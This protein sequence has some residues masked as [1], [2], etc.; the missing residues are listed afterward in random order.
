MVMLKNLIR[1]SKMNFISMNSRRK[2]TD[3]GLN[4]IEFFELLA[5]KYLI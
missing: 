2:K 5:Q 4:A 3:I 1:E